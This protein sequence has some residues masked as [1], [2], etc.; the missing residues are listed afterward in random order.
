LKDKGFFRLNYESQI[1]V[2][3][4]IF[5]IFLL[6]LNFGTDYLLHRAKRV[7]ESRIHQHLTTVALSAGF[8]W[9]NSPKTELKKNLLELCFDS[10]VRQIWFLSPDG[11][12]LLSSRE[13]H[14]TQDGRIPRGTKAGKEDLLAKGHQFQQGESF[15]DLYTDESGL[16]YLSYYAPLRG[17][18]SEGRIWVVVEQEI[19][20]FVGI[21]RMANLNLLVR[22]VGLLIAA[23]VTMLLMRNLL[24]PYRTMIRR[25]TAEKVFLQ[26]DDR[27][28]AG[29]LDA[30]VGI[31]EQVISELK[32]KEKTL[33]E[34]YRQTDRRA[35]NLASYNDYILK[36]MTSGMIVCDREGKITGM[37]GPAQKILN[38][39]EERVVGKRYREVFEPGN[40]LHLAVE[41]AFSEAKPFSASEASFP[42]GNGEDTHLALSSSAV[43]DE[44]GRMLGA[45]VFMTD[46]TE[47]KRLEREIAFKDKMATLGEMSSGLAHELRNSMGAIMGFVKLLKKERN[48]TTS[49]SPT[50]DA[51]FN[52][53]MSMESMLQRFLA[54]AKPYQL[55]IDK[56]N[57]RKLVEECHSALKETFRE[58]GVGFVMNCEPD[59][60]PMLGDALLLKQS[61]QNLMQNSVEAMP[62]GGKLTVS[63]RQVTPPSGDEAIS[64]EFTDTGCGIAKEIQDKV[65]N[66]FFTAKENGTGL[67]L[68]FARKII[69]LH[70]GR[71][72]LKS[73]AGRGTTFIVYLP[74]KPEQDSARKALQ[75]S[76]ELEVL[77]YD[78]SALEEANQK[79]I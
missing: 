68:S 67:G 69:H 29:E 35:K 24:R 59:L 28:K 51:I 41:A 56:V 9:R 77:T 32:T 55:K 66:P 6:L 15:S 53:A 48:E 5:I 30:A 17:L 22:V 37:N 62:G 38:L 16:A 43:K 18:S 1:R 52:E 76:E 70:N 60:A 58:K 54:F 64:I 73:Q 46:L 50:V 21:R 25:A 61:F 3:L 33:Q 36:S 2:S 44:E 34:L 78:S 23:L 13:T 65:F 11:E 40:P 75:E 57:P 31:F 79:E 39:S 19:S 26:T 8:I 49:Q 10:G 42:K 45:V 71:I 4:V 72:E 7:L 47:I 74:L 20:G 12:L 63:L 27:K 14:S